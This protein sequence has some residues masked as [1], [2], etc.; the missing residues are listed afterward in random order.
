MAGQQLLYVISALS[1]SKAAISESTMKVE[2][3]AITLLSFSYIN[4]PEKA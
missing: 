3:Y 2:V 4:E 1:G